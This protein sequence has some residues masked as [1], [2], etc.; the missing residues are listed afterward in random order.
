MRVLVFQDRV[1]I[2]SDIATAAPYFFIPPDYTSDA[3]KSL[4]KTVQGDLYPRVLRQALEELENVPLQDNEAVHATLDKIKTDLGVNTMG[5]M[6][7]IRHALTGRKVGPSV[8]E[9][10]GVLGWSRT[11]ERL[12]DA[13]TCGV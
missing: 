11:E 5:V 12:K 10:L 8:V 1:V 3:A 9:I 13:L 2:L 6:N 7:T 4:R